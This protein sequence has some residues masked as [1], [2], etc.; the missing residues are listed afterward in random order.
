MRKIVVGLAGAVFI[1]AIGFAVAAVPRSTTLIRQFPE[2]ADLPDTKTVVVG[3]QWFGLSTLSPMIAD[4][5]LELHDDQFTGQGQFKVAD[6]PAVSRSIT[7]PRDVMRA[8]LAVASK[9]R[10]VEGEYKPRI[11]HTD[12]YP[13]LEFDVATKQGLLRIGTQSQLKYAESG[14]YLNRTPW[15]IGYLNRSFVVTASD[16]DRAYEPFDP[17]LRE[18]EI[19]KELR[20]NVIEFGR[21]A[22]RWWADQ[23]SDPPG[24]AQT[25]TFSSS[26]TRPTAGRLSMRSLCAV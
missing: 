16:L 22:L 20:K 18:D 6:A 10:M 24:D 26:T 15:S 4:Y 19:F 25:L 21:R 5:L 7:V 9:V 11:E 1:G 13:S 2:M 23:R 8:F 3:I 14:T 12:D 17:Y